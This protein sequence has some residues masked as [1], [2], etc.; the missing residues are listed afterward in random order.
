MMSVASLLLLTSA[1]LGVLGSLFFAHGVIR[2]STE[3]MARLAGTYF[4]ANPY[5]VRALAAQRADY[6]FGGG[7]I[8]LAFVLQLGSFFASSGPW[9]SEAQTRW[10]PGLGA[11]A[12]GCGFLFLRPCARLLTRVFE[13][14]VWQ[15][16]GRSGDAANG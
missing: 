12:T 4:D 9:L 3:M 16:L 6:V 14:R 2:Q 7:L 11:I 13:K 5:V 8:V 10:A 1:C 15:R